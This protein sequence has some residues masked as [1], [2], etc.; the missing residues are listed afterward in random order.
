[1][2]KLPILL[3]F[4]GG[5]FITGSTMNPAD[6]E[7]YCKLALRAQVLIVS[8]DYRLAPEHPLP[9]A[10]Q[11][12]FE[13]LTWLNEQA[14]LAGS[15]S[16]PMSPDQWL[17]RH[18]DFSRC[19]L[20]GD[21]AGANI[22]HHVVMK[23]V[24][25]LGFEEEVEEEEERLELGLGLRGLIY[26]HPF[27]TCREGEGP[28]GS[29]LERKIWELSGARDGGRFQNPLV[30]GGLGLLERAELP[31]SLVA[32]AGKDPTAAR[33]SSYHKALCDAGKPCKL[34]LSPG[35]DHVFHLYSPG[36]ENFGPFIDELSGFLNS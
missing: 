35:E 16:A 26:I 27:F 18:G 32:V 19:F 4:H 33:G 10:Y 36:S 13:A 3:Y 30:G 1:M 21:S 17:A 12:C 15:D 20:G 25:G 23:A 34:L 11:D 5:G 24:L 6:H 31:P 8:I 2:R 29:E 22:L 14:K 7:F 9:A 28:L